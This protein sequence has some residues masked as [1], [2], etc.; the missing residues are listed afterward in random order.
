MSNLQALSVFDIGWLRRASK[1]AGVI[2]VPM[3]IAR[4]LLAGAYVKSD[5]KHCLTIT[6]K[7]LLALRHLG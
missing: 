4:R 7:G 6:S 2:D 3:E 1:V 5:A